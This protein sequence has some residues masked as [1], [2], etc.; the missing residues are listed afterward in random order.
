ML[1]ATPSFLKTGFPAIS[2]YKLETPRVDPD[3]PCNQTCT[4]RHV[5]AGQGSSCNGELNG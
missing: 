5:N 1:D 4:H 3:F 2:R